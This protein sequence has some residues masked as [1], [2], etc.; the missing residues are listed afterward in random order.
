MGVESFAA[1]RRSCGDGHPKP[2]GA[3]RGLEGSVVARSVISRWTLAG[4]IRLALQGDLLRARL[5]LFEDEAVIGPASVPLGEVERTTSSRGVG[6]DRAIERATRCGASR[7]RAT[8]L[9][10]LSDFEL[11]DRASRGERPGRP[12]RR[13]RRS[14]SKRADGGGGG[15][16][17]RPPRSRPGMPEAR[18]DRRGGAPGQRQPPQ[19]AARVREP[20]PF[21][22]S[23]RR[24]WRAPTARP[25]QR[26]R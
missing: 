16:R 3:L 24:R 13:S 18:V 11:V 5:G 25:R 15:E 6:E 1:C 4:R 26:L 20:A 17:L 9:S 23:A 19:A 7:R 14:S 22:C 21:C 8:R 10:T 2:A 12:C